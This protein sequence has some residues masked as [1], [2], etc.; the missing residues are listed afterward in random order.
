MFHRHRA[1]HHL[2]VLPHAPRGYTSRAAQAD[3]EL[4]A[5]VERESEAE[6]S[7]KAAVEQ[8]AERLL[9]LFAEVDA[10][11]QRWVTW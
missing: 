1:R 8:A 10:H 4:A 6:V 2:R 11:T 5:N 7:G 3:T 9:P